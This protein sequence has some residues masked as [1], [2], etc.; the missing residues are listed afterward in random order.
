MRVPRHPHLPGSVIAQAGLPAELAD[1]LEDTS[2]DAGIRQET[3]EALALTGK[4]AGTP[5]IQFQ[6][7]AGVAFFG[8]VIS[9]LPTEAEAV[10]LWDTMPG[11]ASFPGFAEPK[12]SVRER[13]TWQLRCEPG[14]AGA[15]EDWNVG[16]RRAPE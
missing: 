3:G 5:I 4:D 12:R 7:P 11:L 10:A 13:A 16:S 14:Q 8:P 15:G 1:A 2:S 6:L 9:R